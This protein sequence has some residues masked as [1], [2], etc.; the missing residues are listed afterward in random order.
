[1]GWAWA[2]GQA[3]LMGEHSN[4]EEDGMAWSSPGQQGDAPGIWTQ[5][6][7]VNS[8][9]LPEEWVKEHETHAVEP[10]TYSKHRIRF[11]SNLLLLLIIGKASL[12]VFRQISKGYWLEHRD[13]PY[14]LVLGCY[15]PVLFCMFSF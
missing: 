9:I 4:G 5:R 10:K 7:L 13:P 15:L 1:M 11:M 6:E 12:V 14:I 3:F 8:E 2:Q